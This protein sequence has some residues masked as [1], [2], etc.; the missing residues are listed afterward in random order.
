M[1]V[2]IDEVRVRNQLELL[3]ELSLETRVDQA[4]GS[5]VVIAL[6]G[7]EKY[8]NALV[9]EI[10]LPESVVIQ[11]MYL[12]ISED[13]AYALKINDHEVTLSQLP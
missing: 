2:R 4:K 7:A 6:V 13:V 1:K 3:R 5:T 12:R 11:A 9:S 8:E 10:A